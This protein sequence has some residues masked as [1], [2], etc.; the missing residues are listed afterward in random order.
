MT[1]SES[2]AGFLSFDTFYVKTDAIPNTESGDPV[3]NLEVVY[4]LMFDGNTW[5]T[6]ALGSPY[7]LNLVLGD[8]TVKW[9]ETPTDYADKDIYIYGTREFSIQLPGITDPSK[10][11]SE[12]Y[13]HE[14]YL[15]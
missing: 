2:D 7:T 10:Y 3:I 4:E 1:P 14:L 5:Y 6:P 12:S 8:D 9:N 15:L 13:S 11:C